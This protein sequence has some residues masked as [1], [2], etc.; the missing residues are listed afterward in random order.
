MK[1]FIHLSEKDEQMSEKEIGMKHVNSLQNNTSLRADEQMEEEVENANL[2]KKVKKVEIGEQLTK[3]KVK[4][5]IFIIIFLVVYG[6]SSFAFNIFMSSSIISISN[7][8]D[9]GYNQLFKYVPNLEIAVLAMH[10]KYK[11]PSTF[12]ITKYQQIF[13]NLEQMKNI[14]TVFD[15]ST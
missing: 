1:L 9:K 5:I 12:N 3:I 2:N 4:S 15:S 10:D 6:L 8:K 7:Y 14:N 13:S 11:N